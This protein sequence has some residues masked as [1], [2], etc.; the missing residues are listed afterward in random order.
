MPHPRTAP[1]P[2][3][4]DDPS[5]AGGARAGSSVKYTA[6]YLQ[7]LEAAARQFSE[8]GYH[9]ATTKDIAE[10]LGVQQGSLYYYI[11]SKEAAL[12]QICFVA[13]KGY[14]DFSAEIRRSRKPTTEK[15]EELVYRHLQ[16][17]EE[18]PDFFRVFLAHRQEL[19]EQPRHDLGRQIRE[20]EANVEGI[21]R[22]GVRRGELRKDCDCHVA[23]LGVMGMCNAVVGWHAKR[24]KQPVRHIAA[25]LARM[26]VSG[27]AA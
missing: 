16:T 14:V 25:E 17:L 18:R 21:L 4:P 24:G 8:K 22:Q 19:S 27:L 12:E 5:A 1:R 20:Y 26:V 2:P 3:A 13:M 9:V 6:K 7:V 11:R 15:L 10:S 23:A